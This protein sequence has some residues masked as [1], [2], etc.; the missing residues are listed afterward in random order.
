MKLLEWIGHYGDW[1][2]ANLILSVNVNLAVYKDLLDHS[3]VNA[4]LPNSQ[5]DA[6][7]DA[8]T[9]GLS[10]LDFW[11]MQRSYDAKLN[12]IIDKDIVRER[13]TIVTWLQ[14]LVTN[15]EAREAPLTS[16]NTFDLPGSSTYD[17][18]TGLTFKL[19]RGNWY[20]RNVDGG[21]RLALFR[22]AQKLLP[23]SLQSS[24]VLGSILL[25][26][27]NR[28]GHAK[29]PESI[30]D[31]DAEKATQIPKHT[32]LASNAST[33]EELYS[34]LLLLTR[35][36]F[37]LSNRQDLNALIGKE[38]SRLKILPRGPEFCKAL[39]YETKWLEWA[40]PGS[41]R[42]QGLA[43]FIP[44]L[45]EALKEDRKLAMSDDAFK[46]TSMM[47]VL[48]D[49]AAETVGS[50]GP[51]DVV[52]FRTVLELLQADSGAPVD[53]KGAWQALLAYTLVLPY[54]ALD[55]RSLLV[56]SQP[57][58]DSLQRRDRLILFSLFNGEVKKK[59]VTWAKAQEE[60]NPGAK[61]L[62][63]Q[64]VA[65]HNR[66]SVFLAGQVA[67]DRDLL[68]A[69]AKP[70]PYTSETIDFSILCFSRVTYE[71]N[72]RE[73]LENAVAGLVQNFDL[74]R[75]ELDHS[76]ELQ[77]CENLFGGRKRS[78]NAA[79]LPSL[80][81]LLKTVVEVANST[82]FDQDTDKDVRSAAAKFKADAPGFIKGAM[83]PTGWQSFRCGVPR[84]GCASAN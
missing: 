43:E 59:M 2:Q 40:N 74:T 19:P 24:A 75:D 16:S 36:N 27:P 64:L 37:S 66:L 48:G 63:R 79:E 18:T 72:A 1:S 60:F 9:P 39:L 30:K 78:E 53:A 46:M 82:T 3:S 38:R 45:L 70:T 13:D 50:V 71:L 8:F 21:R 26:L 29:S 25:L 62:M 56:Q 54:Y 68:V 34:A 52:T 51:H 12:P 14:G 6:V 28:P 17:S 5:V 10:Q 32:W 77:L 67:N 65:D 76:D 73:L 61:V 22:A 35:L 31:Y 11:L 23:E 84:R 58:Q 41:T 81:D 49:S 15:L 44:L 4:I 7:I 83:R 42:P 20:R 47:S 55:S 69:A 80:A 33:A 57:G